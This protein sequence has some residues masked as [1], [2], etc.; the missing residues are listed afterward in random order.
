VAVVGSDSGV[1]PEVI[2]D[3]GRVVPAGE[4]AALA[5]ALRELL[6]RAVRQPLIEAGRTRVMQR[7]SDDAVAEETI[8]F[9][10]EALTLPA[11]RAVDREASAA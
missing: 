10:Q 7:F 1:I 4:G 9:W 3:A 5:Q 11:T 6:E 2:G 8:R